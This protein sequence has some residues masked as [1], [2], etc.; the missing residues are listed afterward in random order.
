MLFRS[1]IDAVDAMGGVELTI[2]DEEISHLNNYQITMAEE[3]GTNYTPVREAGTQVLNGLQATAYCRIR[4]TAGDDFKRAERQRN[5][6][7]AMMEK[8]K[9]SSISTL[10][11][12]MNAVLPQISTSLDVDEI[13]PVLGMIADYQMTVSDGFPFSTDRNGA[14][15]G[16]KGSCVIPDTLEENVTY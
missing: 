2:T 1:L 5:L 7:A 6:L 3:L 10:T 13:V 12:V 15:I 4:Y 8:S 14:T 9:T 11:E 16:T